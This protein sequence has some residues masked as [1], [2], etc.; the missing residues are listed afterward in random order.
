MKL[1]EYITVYRDIIIVPIKTE[2]GIITQTFDC[3]NNTV[4]RAADYI[5]NIVNFIKP[6]KTVREA[7]A[8]AKNWCD[9]EIWND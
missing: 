1:T 8:L 9:R 2:A 7:I 3:T 4:N 6:V 5:P